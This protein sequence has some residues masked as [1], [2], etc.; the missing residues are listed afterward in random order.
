MIKVLNT[1]EETDIGNTIEYDIKSCQVKINID[2]CTKVRLNYWNLIDHRKRYWHSQ[3][4]CDE[5][6]QT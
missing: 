4:V 2:K 1:R 5:I 6:K 3:Q